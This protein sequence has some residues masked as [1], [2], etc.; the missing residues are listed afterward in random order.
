MV[1]SWFR[2][3]LCDARFLHPYFACSWSRLHQMSMLPHYVVTGCPLLSPY[4]LGSF[5]KVPSIL[6]SGAASTSSNETRAYA[7]RAWHC[8]KELQVRRNGPGQLRYQDTRR[9]NLVGQHCTS[10]YEVSSFAAGSMVTD[11]HTR[12][13]MMH[14]DLTSNAYLPDYFASFCDCDNARADCSLPWET[15]QTAGCP[16]SRSAALRLPTVYRNPTD[17]GEWAAGTAVELLAG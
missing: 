16:E 4:W 9:R 12:Y 2:G 17:A 6:H 14:H 13:I 1:E 11:R 8:L 3:H 10:T 5:S 15:A 7:W